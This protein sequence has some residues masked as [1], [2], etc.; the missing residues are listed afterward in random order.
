MNHSIQY[1]MSVDLLEERRLLKERLLYPSIDPVVLQK[2]Y[3]KVE[4][5]MKDDFYIQLKD[6]MGKLSDTERSLRKMGLG[7]LGRDGFLNT[8]L[9]Y[10]FIIRILNTLKKIQNY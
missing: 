1:V 10:D 5:C 9:S 7:V 4:A 2:R 8:K 6:N 3:D